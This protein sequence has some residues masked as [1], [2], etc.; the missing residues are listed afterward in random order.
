MAKFEIKDGV[1]IIPE[2]TTSIPQ[3]AFKNE[4][5]LVD[6]YIPDS[7]TSI[8]N[9]AFDGCTGLKSIGIGENIHSIGLYAFRGCSNIEGIV[10][11][12]D[13]QV[14]DS[15]Q[16]CDAIIESDTNTLLVGCKNTVIP[17]SVE[18]IGSSAFE[19]CTGL[20]SINIPRYVNIVS[21]DAFK[22]CT[23]LTSITVDEF[24]RKND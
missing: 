19:G 11:S 7:V 16:D 15:R 3:E 13:N 17:D 12:E 10:V 20:T 24:N 2:G 1:C 6:I 8:G 9:L 21:S 18:K 5:D 22:G 23:G 4:T 14:F